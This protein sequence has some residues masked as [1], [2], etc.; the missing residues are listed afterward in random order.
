VEE[1][2]GKDG[3]AE[4]AKEDAGRD[5][6]VAEV[7]L[8]HVFQELPDLVEAALKL[9]GEVGVALGDATPDLADDRG[10]TL[11]VHG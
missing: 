9:D 1:G 7:R 4:V 2:G 10:Q 11:L 8:A 5:E 6:V 3:G